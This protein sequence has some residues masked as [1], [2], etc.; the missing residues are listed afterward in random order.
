M[1][2]PIAPWPGELVR[3]GTGECELFVRSAPADS[4]AEPA[5]FVHGLGGSATNWTDLMDLLRRPAADQD[6]PA[7]RCEAV[8]LPGFGCSPP[9]PSGE[10]SID[11][12]AVA[13]SDLIEERGYWPVHLVG[14][15]LGGAVCVRLAARR[16]DL[17]RTLTLI[18]PALPDLLPRLVPL[19]V[20]LA[21]T[22]WLGRRLLSH[23]QQASAQDRASLVIKDV[24]AD[25]SRVH[26]SRRAEEVAEVVRRD[27]LEYASQALLAAARGLVTEYMRPGPRSLWRDAGRVTAPV[28]VI[29][30]SHDKLVRPAM[31]ARAARS[32]HGAR[33]VLLPRTG[34]VAMMERP[35][36]V[37]KEMFGLLEAARRHSQ[38][39]TR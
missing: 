34:H 35:D 5:V 27:G 26:P 32:F 30:G 39:V 16:P 3:V 2:D 15:S 18:S 9:P 28:L 17:V 23:A 31:A 37:A 8:D 21:S 22:P 1:A 36:L 38:A 12:A 7:L 13:V 14:N 24:Y 4:D 25:P 29:H 6:G 11:A 33:V 19:R 20:M 10:Y